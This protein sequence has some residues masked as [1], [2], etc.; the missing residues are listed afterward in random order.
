MT[1]S[2]PAAAGRKRL[3]RGERRDRIVTDAAAFFAAR[4][5]DA[6]TRQLAAYAGVAQPLLYR[7]FP[8][9]DAL[10]RAVYERVYVDRWNPEWDRVLADRAQPLNVR[11][12]RFY[13]DYLRTIHEPVWMRIYLQAGL[14]SLD[15][16]RWYIALVEERVIRRIA[17]ELRAAHGAPGEDVLPISRTEIELIWVFHG[18]LFYH[19]VRKEIFGAAPTAPIDDAVD[20]AVD[21][22]VAGA[23]VML[24]D[25][26]K[27]CSIDN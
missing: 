19:G 24:D 17:R 7:Y 27:K 10:I 11:L 18:G 9:K 26:T 23:A 16:N 5:F 20:P 4:G 6:S 8:S 12:K 22:F 25:L 3:K 13:R 15:I 14:K 2:K 1:E 21:S